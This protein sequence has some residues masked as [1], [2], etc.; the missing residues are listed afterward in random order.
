MES[1]FPTPKPSAYLDKAVVS[2]ATMTNLASL[3]AIPESFANVTL[4]TPDYAPQDIKYADA[5]NNEKGT[6]HKQPL[7]FVLSEQALAM[8]KEGIS[9]GREGPALVPRPGTLLRVAWDIDTTY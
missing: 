6:S 1:T 4:V 8:T 9:P 3:M 2:S 5:P 7:S